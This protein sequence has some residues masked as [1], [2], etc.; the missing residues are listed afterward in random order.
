M[1]ILKTHKPLKISRANL[2]LLRECPRCFWLYKHKGIHRPQGYPYTL[3]LAV[4]QLLKAEFDGY[5]TRGELHPVLAG[6]GLPA[7]ARLYP[8]AEQL[9]QWRNNFEGL[10]YHDLGLDATLFGAVD[11]MLEFPDG[12]LAV[13]DYKSSGA[14]EISVYADYQTQM[15]VYTYILE[16]LGHKTARRAYFVFYQVDKTGGFNGRLPFR[17]E[18]REVVTDP[19]YVYSLFAQAVK[20][21]RSDIPPPSHSECQYCVYVSHH[22]EL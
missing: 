7:G 14:K 2:Q 16:Q 8:D 10:K 22:K 4:D 11:D 5:R 3:S 12:A 21:A 19:N 9:S 1:A 17:G 6:A 20:L 15:D 13:V 18:I